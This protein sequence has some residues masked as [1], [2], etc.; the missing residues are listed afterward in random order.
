LQQ[1]EALAHIVAGCVD[2]KRDSQKLFY[3]KFYGFSM[4]VCTRYCSEGDDVL[5]VVNDGFLKVFKQIHLFKPQHSDFESSIR[6]WMKSIFVHTAIDH[7]R[8]R[9]KYNAETSLD[10][11]VYQFEANQ[12]GAINNLTYKELIEIIQRLSPVYRTVFN[13]YVIDG[14]K[15]EEIAE[16]L[17]ISVGASKSNL[18]KAR[19]NIQK[20]LSQ[21][22]FTRYEGK[23]I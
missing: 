14:Y 17:G 23:A 8:K 21:T 5:E 1:Q 11:A 3:Q 7:Y 13:L 10:D 16:Q 15:H 6:G 19:A 18:S 12:A 4:A 20:M 22:D 9:K 2:A